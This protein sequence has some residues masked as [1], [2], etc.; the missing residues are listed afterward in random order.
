MYIPC[1]LCWKC[2]TVTLNRGI[3]KRS[4][5]NMENFNVKDE[6]WKRNVQIK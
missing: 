2:E 3:I 4:T 5:P 1:Y 6:K